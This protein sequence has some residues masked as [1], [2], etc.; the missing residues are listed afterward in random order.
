M[1]RYNTLKNYYFKKYGEKVKKISV[2]A[3]FTCPNRDGNKGIGGC[4]Y[5]NVSS[6]VHVPDGDIKKQA[7]MQ[8][9]KYKKKGI[10]KYSVYFQSYS[11]TYG[12]INTIIKTI[13]EALVSD[14]IVEIAIGTR[15]DVVENEK[16]LAIKEKYSDYDVVFELGLQ[17]IFDKTLKYINRGHTFYDFEDAVNR[18]KD[19]NFKVC[20]HVI[21]G[22]PFETKDMMLETMKY[23]AFKRIDF[24]K[25]HHLHIVKDTEL[26]HIYKKGEIKLIDEDEYL[27]LLSESI[28]ILPKQTVISRLVGDAPKKITVAP[29][30]PAS[31]VE[32]I[33]KFH[34]YLG[35]YDIIQ[36]ANYK[37]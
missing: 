26:E 1:E 35:S 10:N 27:Y 37:S 36:G 22:L 3:S 9:K 29:N 14:D 20:A 6:F 11:N 24:V 13:D 7:T 25:F 23:L 5:C 12:S 18:L 31:K 28:K 33:N 15:A 16:L 8:I 21:F 19:L 17:S 4:I 30:W 32:F 2:D 34:K